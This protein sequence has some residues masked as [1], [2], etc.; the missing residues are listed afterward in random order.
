VIRPATVGAPPLV[1]GETEI[2]EHG[3]ISIKTSAITIM[4]QYGDV[5]GREVQY[6]AKF[7][8]ALADLVFCLLSFGDVSR[9]ADEF[10]QIPGCA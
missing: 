3:L 8:L 9:A 5:L 4:T 10:H 1:K 2:I 6:L 7:H